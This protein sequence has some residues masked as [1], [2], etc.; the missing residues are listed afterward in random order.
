VAKN[1]DIN[2]FKKLFAIAMVLVL[3]GGVGGYFVAPHLIMFLF[4]SEFVASADVFNLH[5]IA[6][7]FVFPSLM[8]GYP[9]LAALGFSKAANYS[10]VAGC[11]VFFTMAC[12]GYLVGIKNTEFF[13]W[14]VIIA[15][16]IVFAI[17]LYF[18]ITRV[19]LPK[20]SSIQ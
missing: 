11:L 15:E 5:I 7:I 1:K 12:V 3:L 6:L 10:V 16:A 4:G 9:L 17:R 13:V 14:S 20:F 8:L 18:A 2:L 19:F